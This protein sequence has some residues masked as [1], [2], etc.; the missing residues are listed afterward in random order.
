[1]NKNTSP[2]YYKKTPEKDRFLHRLNIKPSE[3]TMLLAA[4]K[5]VRK[6]IREAFHQA[7][8]YLSQQVAE[9]ELENIQNIKPK[10][11]TQGSFAYRTLNAPCQPGQEIDLD[12]GVYLPMSVVNGSPTLANQFMFDVVDGAL[13]ALAKSQGWVFSKKATCSRVILSDRAHIDVPLYAIPDDRYRELVALNA[14]ARS[15]TLNESVMDSYTSLESRKLTRLDEDQ[16]WLAIRGAEW[17]ASDP[18]AISDWFHDEVVT[19]GERLR[20]LCR[21]LKAWRDNTWPSGGPSSIALM[22][23][24]ADAYPVLKDRERDDYAL[25]EVV[26][27]LSDSIREVTNPTTRGDDQ[28]LEVVYPRGQENLE[29]VIRE[30]NTLKS[31]LTDTIDGAGSPDESVML[32]QELFGDRVPDR[33]DWIEPVRDSESRV[34]QIRNTPA[35]SITDNVIPSN[36]RSG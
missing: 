29:E 12:D 21:Y 15:W 18:M 4:R 7:R 13:K 11:F 33:P 30:V 9:D 23:C 25:L 20:R 8:N 16:V 31:K 32:M 35:L 2:I 19:K 28:Q 34:E 3:E 27:K 22:I 24:A 17:R 1:M 10:F 6:A 26:K 14:S 36:V 5:Q